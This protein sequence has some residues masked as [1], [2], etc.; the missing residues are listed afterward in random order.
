MRDVREVVML[1]AL[2]GLIKEAGYTMEF[3]YGCE[4]YLIFNV[5]GDQALGSPDLIPGYKVSVR[6]SLRK[7]DKET[8]K[9]IFPIRDRIPKQLGMTII[10]WT[11]GKRVNGEDEIIIAFPHHVKGIT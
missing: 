8:R 1:A 6:P 4:E 10:G 3:I 5:A 11:P 7:Y 2:R 9:Y